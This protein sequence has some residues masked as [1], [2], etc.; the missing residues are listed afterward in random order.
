MSRLESL[1]MSEEMSAQ[2]VVSDQ[3][4]TLLDRWVGY[5]PHGWRFAKHTL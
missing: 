3:L 5:L 4:G 2:S 1:W